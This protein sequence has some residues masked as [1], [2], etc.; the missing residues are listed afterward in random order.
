M[1]TLYLVRHGTTDGNAQGIFQG[2][3]DLPLNDLGHRQGEYLAKRF[4]G[5][6]LDAVYSSPL[7]RARQTAEFLCR[8][9]DLSPILEPDLME[10]NAGRLDGRLGA[11][12]ERDYPEVMA[13]LFSD[14]S[15]FAPPKGETTQQVYDR[16]VSRITQIAAENAGKTVAVVA[17]GFAL[18]TY[19]NFM[20]GIPR[21]RLQRLMMGNM[22]VSTVLYEDPAHPMLQTL[23]DESHIPE[24]L[25]FLHGTEKS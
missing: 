16:V 4:E 11:D 8:G 2:Q 25:R 6:H 15:R 12:N 20:R 14:I 19:N 5:V 10:I 22:A 9:R 3:V 7:I 1:T 21:D 23:A 18:M 17:H 24:E 13:T